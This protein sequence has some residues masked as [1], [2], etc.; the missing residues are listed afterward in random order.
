MPCSHEPVAGAR[1]S[2]AAYSGVLGWAEGVMNGVA[3]RGEVVDYRSVQG[4]SRTHSDDHCSVKFPRRG[5]FCK[6]IA[7]ANVP[8]NSFPGWQGGGEEPMTLAPEV[9]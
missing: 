6:G 9:L 2:P 4:F 5:G 3:N 1:C 8:A 7:Q